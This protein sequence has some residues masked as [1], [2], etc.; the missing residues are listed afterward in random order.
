MA[1]LP[2]WPVRRRLRLDP[3]CL[4]TGAIAPDFAYFIQG[5][6][7]H[8]FSHTLIGCWP[9]GVPVGL[10]LAWLFHAVVKWPLVLV[11]PAAIARR[12]TPDARANWPTRWSPSVLASCAISAAIG[13]ATHVVWDDFT[14]ANAWG[15]RH[16][17]W[18][19]HLVNAPVLG[20]TPWFHVLQYVCSFVGISVVAL[21]AAL[22][23]RRRPPAASTR[24][25]AW[26][27]RVVY[28]AAIAVAVLAVT[29]ARGSWS[30]PA[31][32]E[33]VSGVVAGSLAGVVLASLLLA[34]RARSLRTSIDHGDSDTESRFSEQ[35]AS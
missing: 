4:V 32:E 9:W 33:R 28:I 29:T 35:P 26:S 10:V 21:A 12:V 11:A 7:L 6:R 18:L 13:A 1:V 3:T 23:I 14:H 8:S 25:A 27:A 34:R 17:A 22:A 16:I 20:R 31:F 5:S 24:P 30:A 15:A 19:R 2:L